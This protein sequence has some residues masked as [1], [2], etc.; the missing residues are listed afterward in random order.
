MK[1]F[2]IRRYTYPILRVYTKD[3]KYAGVLNNDVE[4]TSFQIDLL[5]ANLTQEYYI[6][7]EDDKLTFNENAELSR[8]PK[9]MYDMTLIN[10]S[11]LVKLRKARR[12]QND[13]DNNK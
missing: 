8:W 5:K 2:P 9:G 6:M 3:D 10:Y 1:K 12:E 11:E 7:H 13:T 4:L